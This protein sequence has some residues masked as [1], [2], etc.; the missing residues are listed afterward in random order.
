MESVKPLH[1]VCIQA[2]GKYGDEYPNKLQ[3]MLE[4]WLEEPFVLT[5][6]CDHDRRLNPKIQ[7][8]DCRSWGLEGS[9]VKL[10]L[11]DRAVFEN[12]FLF[13]DQAIA[14]KSSMAPMLKL[15][16]E[17]NRDLIAMRDWNYNSLGTPVVY[18]RPSD[19]TQ[20]I[21]DSYVNGVRYPCK[22]SAIGDQDHVDAYIEDHGLQDHVGY[23]Q[24]EWVASY[25]GLRAM[26]E[27]DPKRAKE[28]L[29]QAIIVKFHGPP[30]NDQVLDPVRN[31]FF[32]LKRKPHK[33]LKWP[34]YLAKEITEWWR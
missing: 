6:C 3:S 12:E 23:I 18:L 26:N 27:R 11:Y 1:I 16:R 21:Y 5:C 25:K 22:S 29:D 24:Q 17:T 7:I 34:G 19:V 4:R 2:G 28:L 30:K 13:L 9:F 32:I 8:V 14:I 15:F 31:F 33:I 10:K 20:G